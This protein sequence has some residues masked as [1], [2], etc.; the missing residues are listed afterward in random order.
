MIERVQIDLKSLGLEKEISNFT[1]ISMIEEKLPEPNKKE[2]MK[3]VASTTQP[4]IA[5]DNFPTLLNLPLEFRERT[6]YKFCDL[7]ERISEPGHFSH[8][9]F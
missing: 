3:I 2:F 4:G 9:H 8:I 5:K 7:R 6:E 1:I